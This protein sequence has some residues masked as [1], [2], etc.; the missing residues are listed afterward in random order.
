MKNQHEDVHGCL[1]YSSM[2]TIYIYIERERER[3]R[4]RVVKVR[5]RVRTP[6][7]H[8]QTPNPRSGEMVGI[9]LFI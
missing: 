9:V 2:H 1:V 7:P 4:I 8:R 5:V 3:V 6:G